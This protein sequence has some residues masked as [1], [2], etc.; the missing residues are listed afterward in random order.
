MTSSRTTRGHPRKSRLVAANW[1][2]MPDV[3]AALASLNQ[4]STLTKE[5]TAARKQITLHCKSIQ[6]LIGEQKSRTV[7]KSLM[8]DVDDL[9]KRVKELNLKLLIDASDVEKKKQQDSAIKYIS[10]VENTRELLEDYLTVRQNDAASVLSQ[11]PDP[12]EERKTAI[13]AASKRKEE[14]YQAAVQASQ[15][16]TQAQRDME[17]ANKDLETLQAGGLQAFLL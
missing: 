8:V 14:T 5:R 4:I 9:M 17:Q 11:I 7:A 1:E 15:A 13:E 16:A 2:D 3:D 6:Q 12:D 10:A